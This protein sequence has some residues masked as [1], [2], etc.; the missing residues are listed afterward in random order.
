ML[1]LNIVYKFSVLTKPEV[2]KIQS[3][4]NWIV[5][6]NYKVSAWLGNYFIITLPSYFQNEYSTQINY[7]NIL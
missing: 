1:T 7:A 3:I 6:Y 4:L 5:K 2:I